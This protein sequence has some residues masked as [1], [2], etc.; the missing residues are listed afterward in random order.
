GSTEGNTRSWAT[1]KDVSLIPYTAPQSK[2][3][4]ADFSVGFIS[5][6]TFFQHKK[7]VGHATFIPYTTEAEMKADAHYDRPWLTPAKAQTIDLNG[8]WKFKYIAGTSSGPG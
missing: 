6:Q 8:V 4:P 2:P 1:Y 7:E 3:N 5:D